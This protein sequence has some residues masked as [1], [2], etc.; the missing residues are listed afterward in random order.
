M[1]NKEVGKKDWAFSAGCIPFLYSGNTQDFMSHDKIS[2]LNSTMEKAVIELFV[3]YED[4]CPI[5]PYS[6]EINP[7]RVKKIRFNDLIDPK[8]L[9]L[10]RKYSCYIQCNVKVV[11]QYSRMNTG[12]S[13]GAEVSTMAYGC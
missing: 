1:E 6:I 2:V 5:G 3:F 12:A 11:I 7:R 8:P 4:E 10:G 13:E 9:V